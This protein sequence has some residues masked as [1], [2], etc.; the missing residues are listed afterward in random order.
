MKTA[1]LSLFIAT[2]VFAQTVVTWR[3]ETPVQPGQAG[4]PA[5]TTD[6]I[7]GADKQLGLYL[8]ALDGGTAGSKPAGI[9]NS[10]DA[11]NGL[12]AASTGVGVLLYS[13]G[14]GA[15][16]AAETPTIASAPDQLAL[17]ALSDGGYLV[18]INS[19]NLLR[20]YALTRD[21]SGSGYVSTQLV[22]RQLPGAATGLAFDDS[23]ERLYAS[24]PTEGV[25]IVE[26]DGGISTA[27]SFSS[28]LLGGTLGGIELYRAGNILFILTTSQSDSAV[29]VN[30]STVNGYASGGSFQFAPPDA[31]VGV[32]LRAPTYLAVSPNVTG[33]PG[34]ALLVQDGF[35]QNYKLVAMADVLAHLT[36]DGGVAPVDAG[37]TP[38]D[39][40]IGSTLPPT[41][42]PVV[43]PSP[44]K[45]KLGCSTGSLVALP[46]L[47]LLWW[48]RR[49]RS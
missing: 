9:V 30:A 32:L 14:V 24:V 48:I 40:G 22:D 25:V 39:G 27:I 12:V 41:S 42:P 13:T 16:L 26:P 17:G 33:Y 36:G 34:G 20:Q 38:R 29:Y 18:S 37:V 15:G 45:E 7:L 44:P 10:I 35:A 31:G 11:R 3:A 2:N 5:L 19:G 1:L 6:L 49:P 43:G 46:A 21:T 8:Y 4:D 23:T 28:G 47:L